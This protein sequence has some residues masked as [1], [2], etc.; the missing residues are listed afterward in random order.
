[1]CRGKTNCRLGTYER[2]TATWDLLGTDI[3]V[4]IVENTKAVIARRIAAT[5]KLT[6]I[7]PTNALPVKN[8]EGFKAKLQKSLEHSYNRLEVPT[9]KRQRMYGQLQDSSV[10]M[11]GPLD[12]D[13]S[14]GLENSGPDS[15]TD[16]SSQ[17]S[18][19]NH[20]GEDSSATVAEGVEGL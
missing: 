14:S 5:T 20:G 12:P 1:M 18:S 19:T 16:Q 3:Q 15:S 11:E 17:G 4:L 10:E 2:L 6:E 13:V 9:H 8:L 7:E